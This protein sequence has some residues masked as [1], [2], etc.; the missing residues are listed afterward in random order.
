M[1]KWRDVTCTMTCFR[2]L[3]L[4]VQIHKFISRLPMILPG[5]GGMTQQEPEAPTLLQNFPPAKPVDRDRRALR[6]IRKLNRNASREELDTK[7]GG[8][9]AV[10][11]SYTIF[12]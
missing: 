8:L 1:D 10:Q 7:E 12:F 4:T 3:H 5:A 6:Q 11:Y 2:S 9:G